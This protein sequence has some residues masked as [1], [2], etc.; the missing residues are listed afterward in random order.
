MSSKF[1]SFNCLRLL[2]NRRHLNALIILLIV[3]TS[4][5]LSFV[6]FFPLLVFHSL[7]IS[8]I[9]SFHCVSLFPILWYTGVRAG[10]GNPSPPKIEKE[11][12]REEEKKYRNEYKEEKR[13]QPKKAETSQ[14]K[15]GKRGGAMNDELEA[16]TTNNF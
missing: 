4:L 14:K 8:V 3:Q 9:V 6:L 13:Q 7:G 1:S 15:M 2:K 5:N 12:S 10:D 16:K 11:E